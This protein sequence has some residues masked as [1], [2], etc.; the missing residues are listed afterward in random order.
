MGLLNLKSMQTLLSGQ[1][2]YGVFFCDG[3]QL[4]KLHKLLFRKE[5]RRVTEP[6]E[7]IHSDVCGPMTETSLG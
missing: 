2:V 4:N 1:G 5:I 6:G 7:M 3:C